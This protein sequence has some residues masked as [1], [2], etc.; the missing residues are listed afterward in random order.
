MV[1]DGSGGG[2]VGVGGAIMHRRTD[3]DDII[4]TA[5]SSLEEFIG[6][7]WKAVLRIV[8]A[9]AAILCH[10]IAMVPWSRAACICILHFARG[11]PATPR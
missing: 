10:A 4:A 5:S 2:A 6:S 9:Y 1:D 8:V 3:E 7:G 11:P